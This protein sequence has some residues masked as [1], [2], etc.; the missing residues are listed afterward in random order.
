VHAYWARWRLDEVHGNHDNHVMWAG[1]A[2]LIG[3]PNYMNQA[4]VAMDR[5]LAAVEQDTRDLP[6]AQKLTENKPADV[7]DQCSDGAGHKVADEVCVEVVTPAIAYGTPRTVAGGP[8]EN[9]VLK[10]QLKPLSR[11]D[12]YGPVPFTEAQWAQLEETFATGVC[13]YTLPGVDQQA[14]LPWLT[15]GDA[16]NVT[17]G[18]APLPPAPTGSGAGWASPAFGVF[19]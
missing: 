3:D 5:W 17:Y 15:Y 16:A 12:D 10:C 14:T 4:L 13:D 1:P 8:R 19:R 11:D 9:H 6:L 2:P 18:G 7:H